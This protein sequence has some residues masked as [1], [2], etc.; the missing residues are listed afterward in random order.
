MAITTTPV[1]SGELIESVWGNQVRSDLI[2]LDNSKVPLAGGSMSGQLTLV[3]DPVNVSHAARK[4]YVD[5]SVATSLPLGGGTLTGG[6]NIGAVPTP[7][8]PSGVAL[9]TNG[10][11][12]SCTSADIANLYLER[13]APDALDIGDRFAAFFRANAQIGTITI[14]SASSVAYNTTSDARL[15]ERTGDVADA[16][17]TVQALGRLAYRGRWIADEGAGEEWI[18]L[19]SQDV[20]PIASFAV[21]GA[22]DA[23][24]PAD[25][26]EGRATGEIIPQQ[27]DH[28]ALVPLLFAALSQA[29]DRIAALEATR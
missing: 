18:F 13:I 27:L 8:G 4:A 10:R 2:M 24:V 1:V 6:I 16:A 23:V 20:E 15:K 12:E 3:G 5:N 11:V 14:A 9:H 7:Q 25:D 17:D 28:G 19:N 22:A 26:L 21:T 29:L